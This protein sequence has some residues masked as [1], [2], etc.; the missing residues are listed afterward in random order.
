MPLEWRTGATS[1]T[2][3]ANFRSH[4]SSSQR[5]CSKPSTGWCSSRPIAPASAGLNSAASASSSKAAPQ[6]VRV[7]QGV[8]QKAKIS[9]VA[10]S[11][12]TEAKQ[13]GVQGLVVLAA[14]IGKDG[15]I[16]NLRVLNSPSPL[17]SQAALDAVRQWK[18]RPYMLNGSPVEVDT[19]ITVNF[20]LSR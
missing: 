14:V 10:P 3:F 13:A 18:Y 20:T 2:G 16:Q 1:I 8:T 7:S 19:R 17:L 4:R 5:T 11:Y 15:N 6:R 9:D 12:P